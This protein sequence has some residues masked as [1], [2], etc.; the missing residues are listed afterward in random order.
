MPAQNTENILRC[1]NWLGVRVPSIARC[2]PLNPKHSISPNPE[3]RNRRQVAFVAFVVVT[4]LLDLQ[5]TLPLLFFS[6]S[7]V[8]LLVA[9]VV[10]AVLSAV[11]GTVT[12]VGIVAAAVVFAVGVVVLLL[13]LFRSRSSRSSSSSNSSISSS[14]SASSI[15]SS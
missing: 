13:V 11:A 10:L 7:F 1:Q 8:W 2:P 14:S 4:C 15:S 5:V 9:A 12:V 6:S 3:T